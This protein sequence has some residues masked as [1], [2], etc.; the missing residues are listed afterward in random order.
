[1]DENTKLWLAAGNYPFFTS[2]WSGIGALL[3]YFQ[4]DPDTWRSFP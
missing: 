1:L 3:H 4:P 2:N